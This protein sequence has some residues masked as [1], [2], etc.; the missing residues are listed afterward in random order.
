MSD[1]ENDLD[2]DF[3][4][5]TSMHGVQRLTEKRH[6]S[7]KVFWVIIIAVAVVFCGTAVVERIIVYF[8]FNVNT[9]IRIEYPD[10]LTFPAVTICNFNRYRLSK[11]SK[12]EAEYFGCVII[13]GIEDYYYYEEYTQRIEE[14]EALLS[15]T[16]FNVSEFTEKAGFDLDAKTLWSCKFRGKTCD[17][18]NFTSVITDYGRCWT[19]NGASGSSLKQF[20][21]GPNNGL[22]LMINV[23]QDEYTETIGLGA[24]LEA[25]LKFL[26]HPQD[27][28]PLVSTRG[29]AIGTGQHA[30]ADVYLNEYDNLEE[31]W[32]QCKRGQQL[33]Y[34]KT[35]SY[36]SCVMECRFEHFVER[37]GC[38]PERYEGPARICEPTETSCIAKELDAINNNKVLCECYLDCK[39]ISY[40]TKL[41]YA[42]IPSYSISNDTQEV[43]NKSAEFVKDNIVMLDVY[44]TEIT[45]QVFKQTKA[46]TFSAL[47]SDIGGQLGLFVGV[48]F[49]TVVEITEYLTMKMRRC[50][51][52]KS[53]QRRNKKS[54][55]SGV[56]PQNDAHG[57]EI[58]KIHS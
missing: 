26:I 17:A 7:Y 1:R 14:C 52:G 57:V 37:C 48:S 45:K 31:P 11:I 12:T 39:D 4:T 54:N 2:Y 30:F 19:F 50:M 36:E 21:P 24:N 38:K 53:G 15:K 8:Q 46:M 27:T 13:L 16:S 22:Q 55:N 29:S 34:Y 49:I 40:D 25:G 43:Y 23:A 6:C 33:E 41:S 28:P 58:K 9:E 51:D 18:K 3:A 56:S 10:N 42:N 5:K 20:Q 32:G 35:Y 44:Y 47:L